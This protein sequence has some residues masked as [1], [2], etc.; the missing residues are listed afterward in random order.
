M[1]ALKLVCALVLCMLVVEPIATTAI[2]CGDVTSKVA[3]C[4]SYLQNGGNVPKACCDGIRS[5][6]NMAKTTPD[7]QTVC[8]CLQTAAKA[9]KIKGNLAETL[10]AKCSVK[11]PYKISTSTNCKNVK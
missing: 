5:L 10:P 8:G 1:A 2:T 3:G 11:I 4:L 9:V 7:R 6:N